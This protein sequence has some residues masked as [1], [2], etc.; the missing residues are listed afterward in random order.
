MDRFLSKLLGAWA[1]VGVIPS[2]CFTSVAIKSKSR[3]LPGDDYKVSRHCVPYIIATPELHQAAQVQFLSWRDGTGR[4][5]KDL[6]DR[7]KALG[8]LPKDYHLSDSEFWDYSAMCNG[9]AILGS[10][11]RTSDKPAKFEGTR[12]VMGD[13]E[14]Q[15]EEC[16][17][18]VPHSPDA[19]SPRDY[20][21]VL[22]QLSLIHI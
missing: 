14:I 22:W 21:Q 3:P 11:K 20:H 6:I 15:R 16:D 1:G 5:Q 2:D 10:T 12:V 8:T 4:T 9:M 13:A 17:I 7:A 19:L 18:P